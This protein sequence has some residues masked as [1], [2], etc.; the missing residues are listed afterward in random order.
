VVISALPV[1]TGDVCKLAANAPPSIAAW[2]T[3]VEVVPGPPI[4]RRP[5]S[6]SIFQENDPAVGVEAR[7]GVANGVEAENALVLETAKPNDHVGSVAVAV[8]NPP[9]LNL[10]L[11]V[12]SPRLLMYPAGMIIAGHPAVIVTAAAVGTLTVAA[13]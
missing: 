13:L 8:I 3:R 7:V 4:V 10:R 6:A 12:Q 9:I 11:L 1:A 2:H 5:I